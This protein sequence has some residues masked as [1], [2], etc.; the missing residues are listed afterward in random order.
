MTVCSSD[1]SLSERV[2]LEFLLTPTTAEASPEPLFARVE[3]RDPLFARVERR[4]PLF[5]RVERRDP[6]FA[7]VDRRDRKYSPTVQFMPVMELV[8]SLFHL[9]SITIPWSYR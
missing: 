3:R 8:T 9:S 4:D 5:A 1:T 2:C 7:R 6:L